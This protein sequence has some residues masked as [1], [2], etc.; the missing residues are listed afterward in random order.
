MKNRIVMFFERP[1]TLEN[2]NILYNSYIKR[3][4]REFINFIKNFYKIFPTEWIVK[5]K[6]I[7]FAVLIAAL[8]VIINCSMRPQPM[9]HNNGASF[10]PNALAMDNDTLREKIGIK[11]KIDTL[12]ESNDNDNDSISTSEDIRTLVYDEAGL[13]VPRKLPDD[14][15]WMMYNTAIDNGIP[16]KIW[17]RLIYMESVWNVNSVS[18]SGAQ[19]YTQLMPSTYRL[20]RKRLHLEKSPSSN[21]KIG[22]FYLKEMYTYW[23]P[24]FKN[25]RQR[26]AMALACYSKGL[27]NSMAKR[28]T[29]PSSAVRYVNWIL[30]N[31]YE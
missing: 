13:R 23:Y 27:S 30:K 16:V 19:S 7:I 25:D 20:Y 31:G 21:I 15:L 14:H 12:T 10:N 8:I 6:T 22:A 2:S 1:V 26:W 18:K 3:T 9:S 28:R 29:V 17:F 4:N 11:M 24:K 5:N